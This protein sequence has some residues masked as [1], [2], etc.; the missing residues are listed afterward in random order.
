MKAKD[1]IEAFREGK[2]LKNGD[3]EIADGYLGMF[4][5]FNVPVNTAEMVLDSSDIVRL[6]S[7]CGDAAMWYVNIL[8]TRWEVSE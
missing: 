1:F 6:G 5:E 8:T 4:A 7:V 3:L 2:K